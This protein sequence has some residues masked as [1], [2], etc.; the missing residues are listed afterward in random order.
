MLRASYQNKQ[1][2]VVVVEVGRSYQCSEV[3]YMSTRAINHNHYAEE[4]S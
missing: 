1:L 3:L 2:V 4:R